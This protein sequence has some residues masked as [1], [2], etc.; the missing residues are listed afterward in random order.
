MKNGSG[1]KRSDNS[2]DRTGKSVKTET[3]VR[4]SL[5]YYI[6]V[7]SLAE[8]VNTK[9]Y[10]K[11]GKYRPFVVIHKRVTVQQAF[12]QDVSLSHTIGVIAAL[13]SIGGLHR[14]ISLIPEAHSS[15]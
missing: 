7:Y 3:T 11:C 4:S 10:V 1:W 14:A 6:K 2:T 9:E 15:F 13:K 8:P 5:N 12:H